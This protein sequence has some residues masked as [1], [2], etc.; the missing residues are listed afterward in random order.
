ML[1]F[2]PTPQEK[3]LLNDHSKQKDQFAKADR[4]LYEMSRYVLYMQKLSLSFEL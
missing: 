3:N 4:F 1:K 2:V